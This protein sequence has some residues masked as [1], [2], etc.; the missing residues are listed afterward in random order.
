MSEKALSDSD[1]NDLEG[2]TDTSS[3]FP[4]PAS[5]ADPWLAARNRADAHLLAVGLRGNDFR[6]YEVDGNADAVG[7]RPGRK[8][9]G[10]TVLIY[11]GADPAVDSL[12]DNETTYIWLYNNSGTATIGSAISGTGWP[13]VPHVK[14]AEVTLASGVIT[15]IVDRRGEGL[16][17]ILFP[18]YT[19]GTRPA[20]GY[21]G[22][23]IFNSDDGQINID[24]GSDWTLPDGTTT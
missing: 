10:S 4:Y 11:A 24:T 15:G 1:A 2:T 8:L 3:G 9:F 5:D 6:V 21:A 12:T 22:R 17:D 7:I 16:S 20:A 18:V 23:A 19:D 14:L 13:A